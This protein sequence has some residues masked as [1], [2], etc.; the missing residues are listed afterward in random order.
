[1]LVASEPRVDKAGNRHRVS[2]RLAG[3]AT[4]SL[5]FDVHEDFSEMVSARS[6]SFAV[7]LLIPAMRVGQD[8]H[9]GGIVTDELL[10]ALN[11]E[12]QPLYTSIFPMYKQ[13]RVTAA[14]APAAPAGAGVAAGFSAG[15]DSYA[16]LHDH[17]L[18][19]D[20]P[21][22]LRVTHWLFNDV[23][24]HGSGDV[25]DT[26]ARRLE[27]AKRALREVGDFPFVD[28][29]SNVDDAFQLGPNN[30]H[31]AFQQTQTVRNASVAHFLAPGIHSW[32]YASS[33]RYSDMHGGR[34]PG[35]STSEPLSLPMLS[36]SSLTLS[37][38]GGQY[39]RTDKTRITAKV[40]GAVEHL[41]VCVMQSWDSDARNCSRCSKCLRTIYTL[42]LLGLADPFFTAKTF[43]RSVYR[44]A[45]HSFETSLLARRDGVLEREILELAADRGYS[46]SSAARVRGRGRAAALGT[47]SRAR[48]LAQRL[49][50]PHP[51]STDPSL[52]RDQR[53]EE[54]GH[55][56]TGVPGKRP[57]ERGDVMG[58]ESS[59]NQSHD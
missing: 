5:W 39:A 24:S 4:D 15:I 3:A 50:R 55:P 36:T 57:L 29:G 20:C 59:T 46:F 53:A 9:L 47:R 58:V 30:T 17:F 41:D 31:V 40:P 21:P 33:V 19:P 8:L 18:A 54:D 14:S 48:A 38:V 6:D 12:L 34:S 27:G 11:H 7:A 13:V 26:F 52:S 28:V 2:V 22:S 42:E 10:Y 35:S 16:L 45:R 51:H 56:G 32:L 37:S 44:G 1:M 49:M 23:G 43:D 25:Q